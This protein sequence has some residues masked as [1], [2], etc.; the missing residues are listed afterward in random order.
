MKLNQ[1]RMVLAI[2]D[3]GSLRAAARDLD[4]TQPSLTH[5]LGE[6]ERELG[7]T[8]FERNARGMVPTPVGQV[9]LRRAAVVDSEARRAREEVAQFLGS[10]HGELFICLSVVAHLALLPMAL[11]LFQQR[12]P[13]VRLRV[14]E[15]A[16]PAVE[17]RLRDGSMDFYIG[18]APDPAPSSEFVV[19]KLFDNTR[20]V[21]ARQG[22]PLAQAR[23]LAELAGASWITT[24]IT[25]KAEAELR[26]LFAQHRLP[27]PRLVLQSESMLTMLSTLMA[28]DAM[29]IALRQL[30]EFP[31]TRSAL[32]RV[33]VRED[34]PAPPVVVVRRAALPLAPAADYFCDMFRRAAVAYQKSSGSAA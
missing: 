15:G 16:F 6:L 13:G 26:E 34:L 2:A 20:A 12:F 32:Q 29:V 33:P 5:S 23:S 1:I 8:L 7:A 27:P 11:P 24:G 22:H 31:L 30:E 17:S 28:T 25:D 21:F 19:E 3:K 10:D 4:M 9:F 14:L 18:A